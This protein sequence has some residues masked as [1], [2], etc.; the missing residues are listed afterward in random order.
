MVDVRGILVCTAA[1]A[2]VL[3]GTAAGARAQSA[4]VTKCMEAVDMGAFKNTQLNACYEQKMARQDKVL[5]AEY[6]RLQAAS[7]KPEAAKAWVLGQRSWLAYRT[8]WCDY[9]SK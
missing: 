2:A 5:N 9:E 6:K 1:V 7:A 4:E 8:S 3:A